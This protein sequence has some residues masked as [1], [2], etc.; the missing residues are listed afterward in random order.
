M[1]DQRGTAPRYPHVFS[2]FHHYSLIYTL[3]AGFSPAYPRSQGNLVS[4]WIPTSSSTECIFTLYSFYH[5]KTLLP[6]QQRG[7]EI[8]FSKI[9]QPC[10]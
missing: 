7:E 5:L 9:F 6:L 3:G 10:S 1:V 8:F 2:E 4:P